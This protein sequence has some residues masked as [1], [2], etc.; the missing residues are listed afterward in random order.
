MYTSFT[1]TTDGA[2]LPI[3]SHDRLKQVLV[4]KL[5]E[6]QHRYNYVTRNSF[7][8]LI[9]FFKYLLGKKK[10]EVQW[11]IDR[12]DVGISTLN[13]T[14]NDVSI[15]QVNLKATLKKVEEKKAATE[16]LIN[17]PLFQRDQ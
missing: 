13:K 16:T 1:T 10:N 8:E 11:F 9:S 15:L 14:T 17:L 6:T 3:Q 7:L 5:F 2:Y 12:L 4:T